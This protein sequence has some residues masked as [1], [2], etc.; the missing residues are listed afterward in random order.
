MCECLSVL[1]IT[2]VLV[3]VYNYVLYKDKAVHLSPKSA[4]CKEW[5]H[6]RLFWSH[7]PKYESYQLILLYFF[8]RFQFCPWQFELYEEKL[9]NAKNKSR[10][11]ATVGNGG[12]QVSTL[13][14]TMSPDVIRKVGL[15]AVAKKLGS[16]GMVRFL[17]QFETG[18]GDYAKERDQWL[19]KIDLQEIISEIG[20][21]H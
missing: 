12:A 4:E 10:K 19:K 20:K 11:F 9:K 18:W 21:N 7:W 14:M 6:S 5:S 16:L 13:A 17:Q 15:E 1:S 8:I 3:Q 2:N